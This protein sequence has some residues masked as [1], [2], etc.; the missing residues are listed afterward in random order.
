M[1]WQSSPLFEREEVAPVGA[2]IEM[3]RDLVPL[4][5]PLEVAPV[6]AWI[7]MN[8]GWR[9]GGLNSKSP[10]LGRGL[11]SFRTC[12]HLPMPGS[13][14]CWGAWIEIPMQKARN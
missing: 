8:T 10:L 14:P 1:L 11:K 5:I 6:G 13:R 3:L 7:E 4:Q 9:F 2:W 12:K